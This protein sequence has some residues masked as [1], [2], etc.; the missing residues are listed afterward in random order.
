M[1]KLLCTFSWL[2]LAAC[3]G[4]TIAPTQ[5]LVRVGVQSMG[6]PLSRGLSVH[7]R[8][9][10]GE[11]RCAQVDDSRDAM[12]LFECAP[13]SILVG[14]SFT[15]GS[16]TWSA[17]EQRVSI[18]AGVTAQVLLNIIIGDVATIDGDLD[19]PFVTSLVY[20]EDVRAGDEAIIRVRASTLGEEQRRARCLVTPEC[21]ES[22]TLAIGW[23]D[24]RATERFAAGDE[25]R[26]LW[27]A[28]SLRDEQTVR[29]EY[30]LLHLLRDGTEVGSTQGILAFRVHPITGALVAEVRFEHRPE[31]TVA[32]SLS[33]ESVAL[34]TVE[35]ADADFGAGE[36]VDV[37]ISIVCQR[38]DVG[39]ER[40][41][42]RMQVVEDSAE[43]FALTAAGE[44]AR[45]L[46]TAE[47]FDRFGLTASARA[48]TEAAA[49]RPVDAPEMFTCANGREVAAASLCDRADDCGDGSDER[50]CRG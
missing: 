8:P 33:S 27:Q 21:G 50:A 31:L 22:A 2:A 29:A 40:Q 37:G 18:R 34:A 11:G 45:C 48:T 46:A 10:E 23:A 38:R 7:A 19:A 14:A 41:A 44:L 25:A 3:Q 47:A 26:L 4:A 28:P 43:R 15:D 5:G 32:L 1:K 6:S 12:A 9:E 36:T 17:P 49:A 42:F 30:R 20:T 24:M 16:G 39:D 13:G 35:V